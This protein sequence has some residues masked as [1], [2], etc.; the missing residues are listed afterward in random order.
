[1]LPVG[2]AHFVAWV[3]EEFRLDFTSCRFRFR[4]TAFPAGPRPSRNIMIHLGES[5]LISPRPGPRTE[6]AKHISA[7]DDHDAFDVTRYQ[8]PAIDT[9]RL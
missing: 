6:R 3:G 2:M 7:H 5:L 1:M 4:A 8:L 9:H